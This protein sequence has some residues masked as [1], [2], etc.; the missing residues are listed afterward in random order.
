VSSRSQVEQIYKVADGVIVGSAIVK[1]IKENIG[2]PNL[3][4]GVANFVETVLA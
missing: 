2:S 4:K 1:T 3:I